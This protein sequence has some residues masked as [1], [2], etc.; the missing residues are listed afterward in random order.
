MLPYT[1]TRLSSRHRDIEHKEQSY[2]YTAKSLS[3]ESF[4]NSR[5]GS[6]EVDHFS[7]FA[8]FNFMRLRKNYAFCTYCIQKRSN[9]YEAHITVTPDLALQMKVGGIVNKFLI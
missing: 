5:E 9:C 7:A 8:I 6:I 3:E 4:S 1:F 2:T